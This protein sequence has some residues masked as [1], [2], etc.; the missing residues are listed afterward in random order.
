MFTV[1][2]SRFG[3][4]ASSKY[5]GGLLG[6]SK[7]TGQLR[8]QRMGTTLAAD[9][10]YLAYEAD[11][12]GQSLEYFEARWDAGRRGVPHN[13][14]PGAGAGASAGARAGETDALVAS[15]H[16]SPQSALPRDGRVEKAATSAGHAHGDADSAEPS[17]C[18][19]C[20]GRCVNLCVQNQL[21]ASASDKVTQARQVPST[22]S[23]YLLSAWFAY[24]VLFALGV[25]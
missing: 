21:V 18:T 15:P 25:L 1:C 8:K 5:A 23:A 3:R 12:A 17:R 19:I 14:R 20:Y 6:G 13:A 16:R 2:C 7:F 4:L 10:K 9:A 11:K 22:A 24:C